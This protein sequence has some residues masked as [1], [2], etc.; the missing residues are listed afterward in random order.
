MLGRRAVGSDLS[1]DMVEASNVNLPWLARQA[2]AALP[3]FT[4]S[5]AD[6]REVEL[7][8]SCAVVSEGYLGPNL[9]HS[10]APDQ[11]AKIRAELLGLYRE[12]LANF[13]RQLPEGGEVS[14]CVPAWRVDKRWQYLGLVDELGALGYTLKRFQHARTPLLYARE[15]Q[16]VGRQL[17]LLRKK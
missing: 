10:P 11:L 9:V 6:A 17:L 2:Q 14:I 12:A 13:G 3:D 1:A 5:Q 15:D 8:E 4:V 16:V 7:P